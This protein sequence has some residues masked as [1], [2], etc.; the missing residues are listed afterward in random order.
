VIEAQATMMR[1]GRRLL[2]DSK[3]E[4][5]ENGTFETGTGRARDLLSLLVRANSSK[6]VPVNQRL[7][8]ADV[9]AR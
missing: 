4:I 8:D 2:A 1:I 3:R 6:E 9:I 5:S 7:S